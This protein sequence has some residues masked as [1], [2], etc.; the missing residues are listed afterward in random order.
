MELEKLQMQTVFLMGH[1]LS[2]GAVWGG[3][4]G[5]PVSERL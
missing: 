3:G 4:E 2:T 5:K 1:L